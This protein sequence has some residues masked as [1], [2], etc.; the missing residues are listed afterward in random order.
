MFNINQKTVKKT[1]NTNA[2]AKKP[3]VRDSVR[4]KRKQQGGY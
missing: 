4:Q 1:P 2:P 3:A